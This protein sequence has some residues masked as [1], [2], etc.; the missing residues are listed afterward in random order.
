MPA[1][2]SPLT[3]LPPPPRRRLGSRFATWRCMTRPVRG[4]GGGR[5]RR[6]GAVGSHP[7]RSQKLCS[8]AC[9]ER[10]GRERE[11]T[12]SDSETGRKRRGSSA[13]KGPRLP[14]FFFNYD[15]YPNEPKSSVS[16]T[17][18]HR[19]AH[20]GHRTAV[21]FA[22]TGPLPPGSRLATADALAPVPTGRSPRPLTT[23]KGGAVYRLAT[24]AKVIHPSC[25]FHAV[26]PLLPA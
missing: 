9:T 19:R 26:S 3:T 17:S 8:A 13:I 2:I 11:H 1:P 6:L 16:A 7:S 25:P 14:F 5:G 4:G 23:V 10:A 22:P 18:K 20:L 15:V 21:F 12:L 24:L